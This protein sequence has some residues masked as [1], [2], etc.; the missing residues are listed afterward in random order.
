MCIIHVRQEL[1]VDVPVFLMFV[2]VVAQSF[3][4]RLVE[5]LRLSTS[6]EEDRGCQQ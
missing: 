2:H 6:F 1:V 4:Y 3:D 5:T